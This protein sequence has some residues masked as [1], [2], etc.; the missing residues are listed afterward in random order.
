MIHEKNPP[1]SQWKITPRKGLGVMWGVKIYKGKSGKRPCIYKTAKNFASFSLRFICRCAGRALRLPSIGNRSARH[2]RFRRRVF[3]TQ[4]LRPP[5]PI[6]PSSERVTA[7][8][9]LP[10]MFVATLRSTRCVVWLS[11]IF[12]NVLGSPGVVGCGTG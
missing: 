1:A 7:R 11:R 8:V 9:T 4:R 2:A 3:K 6:T 12:S 10:V 5:K